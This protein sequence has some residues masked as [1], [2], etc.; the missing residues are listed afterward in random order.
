ME[1]SCHVGI[2]ERPKCKELKEDSSQQFVATKA[3]HPTASEEPDPAKYHVTELG[4]ESSP[5]WGL[6]WLNPMGLFDRSMRDSD[7]EDRDQPGFLTSSNC[8]ITNICCS[9]ITNTILSLRPPNIVSFLL[10]FPS[11]YSPS[12]MFN[13]VYYWQCP[14]TSTK[15]WDSQRQEFLSFPFHQYIFNV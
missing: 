5:H 2:M 14:P 9:E 13:L 3:P 10:Y 11:Y 4:R 7:S 8:E 12:L 15:T 1:T 6:R